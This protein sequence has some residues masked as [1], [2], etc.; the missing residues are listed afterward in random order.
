MAREFKPVDFLVPD[1]IPAEGVTL[2]VA[3]SKVGKSW[4]LYDIC[5]SAA[6]GRELLGGRKPKQGH[7]LYLALEDNPR[8]LRSRGEK[9]LGFHVGACPGVHVATTWS[10][11]DE[12]G[13]QLIRDWVLH[14][15]AQGQTVALVAIDVLKMVRPPGRDRQSVYDKDYEALQ[16][17]RNL[18]SELNVAVLIAHHQRKASA[19]DLQD[20]VSGTQGLTGAADCVIVIER[21]ANGG[22][23]LDVRGRDVEAQQLT[24]TFDKQACRWS[25]G[26][27]ASE[28]R[29]SET[30]RSISES[31]KGTPQGMKPGDITAETGLKASTVRATLLRMVRSGE[32]KKVKGL[33][34]LPGK[35]DGQP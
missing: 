23:V 33:Y 25:V 7:S 6:L 28:A 21:Q 15:R 11:V 24:A 32:A 5:I 18:A 8:R 30:R 35:G 10:R 12:D 16:G 17:L 1:L 2:L 3:K 14:T 29:L 31:L 26:G 34:V 13:L 4:M 20:T 22:F 27:D 19:D 9:L